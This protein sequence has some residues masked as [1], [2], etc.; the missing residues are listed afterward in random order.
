VTDR[1]AL[2][3]EVLQQVV[4]KTDGVPLFVEELTKVLLESGLLT[5]VDDHYEL[6]RPFSPLAI[7]STLQDSLMARLDQLG[8]AKDIAQLGAA[9]GREFS[10]E[11]LHAVSLVNEETLQSRLKQLVEAE[12]VYQRS[13]P[14]QAT[15]RFKHALVQDT[16]YQSLLKSRRQPLHQQI[17]QVL[18]EQFPE[19]VETQPE[20]LAHHYTEAGLTAQAIPYWQQAGGRAIRR[21]AYLEAVAH[22]TRGSSCF[23]PCRTPLSASSTNSPCNSR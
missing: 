20:L 16:A 21:S 7:P 8:P 23:R 19:T 4:S 3:L 18:A 17:V 13:L 12:L 14:P 10:Y 15:Y 22:L 9:I 1:K 5:T 6:T 11:L 2:P